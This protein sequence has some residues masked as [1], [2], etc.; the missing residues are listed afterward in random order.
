[1][2]VEEKNFRMLS[3]AA[4]HK[5]VA[6]SS[7]CLSSIRLKCRVQVSYWWKKKLEDKQGR[8]MGVRLWSV[9]FILWAEEH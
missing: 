8:F 1:M 7:T 2:E 4:E 3:K 6:Y 9:D 5:G